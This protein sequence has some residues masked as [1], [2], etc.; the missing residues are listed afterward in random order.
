[1]A[2]VLPLES[3]RQALLSR[4]I[5]LAYL[6]GSQSR[7]QSQPGSDLDLAVLW[8]EPANERA[9][10]AEGALLGVELRELTGLPVDLV[11][12]NFAGPLVTF[13]AVY[14]GEPILWEDLD[15]R[16]RFELRVRQRY[17][18]FCHI[19]SFFMDSLRARLRR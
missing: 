17:E 11:P 19:Q 9:L 12:L 8:P 4:G 10:L 7:G 5:R 13:E 16:V 15:E 6:F 14:R 3:I 2:H 18:D 1:M